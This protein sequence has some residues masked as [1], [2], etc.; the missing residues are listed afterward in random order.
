MALT[1][2]DV[3]AAALQ[4]LDEYG[5]ADLTMRRL[6]AQ[7][8]VQAGALYYHVANKQTLLAEVA[9]L[10]LADLP[11]P[12]ADIDP[13]A[14]GMRLHSLLR[15]HRSGAELVSVAL[16][17]RPVAQSPAEHL[18]RAWRERLGDR[19]RPL[20]H[21]VVSLVLGHT[22][23]EEQREQFARLGVGA[24]DDAEGGEDPAVGLEASLRLLAGPPDQE[25]P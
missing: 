3:L 21:G 4:I 9:D 20:A 2:A 25:R 17:V 23:D 8:D 1:K 22:L 11:V 24:A 16:A 13:V 19:A 7:L 18:A 14:W 5:L 12:D 10:V 6:A 15:S